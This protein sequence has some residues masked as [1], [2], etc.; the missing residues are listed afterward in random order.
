MQIWI[1]HLKIEAGGAGAEMHYQRLVPCLFMV[2]K[3]FNGILFA[4]L[5]SGNYINVIMLHI[6]TGGGRAYIIE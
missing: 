1:M 3:E 6:I 5:R 4:Y 2:N